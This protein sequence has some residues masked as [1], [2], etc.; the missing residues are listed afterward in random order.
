LIESK[1]LSGI[2]GTDFDVRLEYNQDY[3]IVHIPEVK[4]FNKRAFLEMKKLLEDWLE[5]FK[6][7]GKDRLFAGIKIGDSENKL[8]EMLNF[9]Y[10]GSTDD[11]NVYSYEG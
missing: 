4:K 11:M 6:T 3:I 8:A 10:I 7:L 5:F 2:K 1:N 9:K